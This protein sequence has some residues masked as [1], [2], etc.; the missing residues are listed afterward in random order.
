MDMHAE[1][2]DLWTIELKPSYNPDSAKKCYV[3]TDGYDAYELYKYGFDKCNREILVKS[4][5]IDNKIYWLLFVDAPE[6]VIK[7][8]DKFAE[9]LK[10]F[11]PDL[12]YRFETEYFWKAAK[13]LS[14]YRVLIGDRVIVAYV[15]HTRDK[16]LSLKPDI[17]IDKMDIILVEENE[18]VEIYYI[19]EI[20]GEEYT[21]EK[22]Y[23]EIHVYRDEKGYI[24]D[25]IIY[26]ELDILEED[27]PAWNL[28]FNTLTREPTIEDLKKFY[29]ELY[30]EKYSEYAEKL[31]NYLEEKEA[32][33]EYEPLH[34]II[35]TWIPHKP[36][37]PTKTIEKLKREVINT[38]KNVP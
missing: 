13:V 27:S 14:P 2:P 24:T 31:L 28:A 26:K 4:A 10:G 16:R 35:F 7:D 6:N 34:G 33:F 18:E 23:S 21:P 8:L 22:V 9:G 25:Y 1:S 29:K 32:Y 12:S 30:K 20:Y 3:F 5:S 37:K 19:G 11:N 36:K 38:V 15:D 17:D